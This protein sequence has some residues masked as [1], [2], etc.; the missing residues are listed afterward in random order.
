MSPSDDLPE[1]AIA[2]GSEHWYTRSV[3]S[4]GQWVGIIEYHINRKTNTPCMGSLAF[5]VPERQQNPTRW[6]VE[7]YD[8]LTL[9]PSLLCG[10]CGDHGFIRNG[11]W[12]SC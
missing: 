1:D 10:I 8:P 7:C 2:L 5:D 12:V 3:S 6:T 9:S 11:E 4:S